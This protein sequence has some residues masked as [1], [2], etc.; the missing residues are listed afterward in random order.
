MISEQFAVGHMLSER[1]D[2]NSISYWLGEWCRN[3][4]P[5]PKIVVVDQSLAL[6]MAVVQTFTQYT[7]LAKYLDVCS[8]LLNNEHVDVPYCMLR[9]DFAHI[10]HL[11]SGWSEIKQSV[12]R[13]KR[14]YLR[15]IALLIACE[16]FF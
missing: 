12:P 2:N 9:N 7:T 4:I 13:V 14:F 11:V 8:S 10:M 15:C 3:D 16:D 6:M 5:M 1:H